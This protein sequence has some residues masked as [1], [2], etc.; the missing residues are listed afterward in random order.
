MSV[1]GEMLDH[2]VSAPDTCPECGTYDCARTEE[3]TTYAIHPEMKLEVTYKFP[4]YTCS[5]GL[6][7][8]GHEEEDAETLA[9]MRVLEV[10]VVK[11]WE[12]NKSLRAFKNS[13]DEALNS[14]DGTYRP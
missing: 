10:E 6:S 5:C 2:S 8:T 3:E 1:T 11:L 12:E 13:V 7:W 9:R 14:G 4:S